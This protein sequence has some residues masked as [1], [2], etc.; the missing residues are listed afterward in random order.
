[1]FKK[2]TSKD[3][4]SRKKKQPPKS[5]A[6]LIKLAITGGPLNL[7]STIDDHLYQKNRPPLVSFSG[8]YIE[9]P[10]K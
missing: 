8:N 7:S 3:I 1:M 6:P 4:T 9:K 2:T 5:L 10:P